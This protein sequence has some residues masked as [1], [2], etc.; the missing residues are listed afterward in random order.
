MT[1]ITTRLDFICFL[2][3]LLYELKQS[4]SMWYRQLRMVLVAIG[5]CESYN[6]PSL[7]VYVYDRDMVDVDDTYSTHMILIQLHKKNG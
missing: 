5:F 7:F 3:K 2:K 6:D 4:S 1:L